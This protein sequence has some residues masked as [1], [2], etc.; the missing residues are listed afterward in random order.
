MKR[1]FLTGFFASAAMA[2]EPAA[3]DA[4]K[5]EWSLGAY[6]VTASTNCPNARAEVGDTVKI[7]LRVE[8]KKPGSMRVTFY[9]SGNA[10]GEPLD[11]KFG[12][13]ERLRRANGES[14]RS[15]RPAGGDNRHAG[16]CAVRRRGC[17]RQI[18]LT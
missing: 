9:E 7:R 18:A 10:L 5:W 1:L 3:H 2:A 12:G 16:I 6:R 11:G 17:V 15:R 14:R 4:A 13:G 8:S